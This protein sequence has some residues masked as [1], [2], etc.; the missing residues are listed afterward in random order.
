MKRSVSIL[1]VGV[2]LLCAGAVRADFI[3]WYVT[4]EADNGEDRGVVQFAIDPAQR[5]A[6]NLSFQL[7][8][9][10]SIMGTDNPSVALGTIQGLTV[11]LDGDPC[12]ALS[13]NVTSGA[14]A[15]TF[16]ISSATVSFS[17][18]HNPLAYASAAVTVTDNDSDGATLTGQLD[19]NNAYE[20]IY[21]TTQMWASLLEVPIV[22]GADDSVTGKGRQ[23]TV[24]PNR[25]T[26][27]ADVTSIQ[28]KFSF[29]LSANDQAS[30]TSRFDIIVPEPATLCLLALGGLAL[31]RR[32]RR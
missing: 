4:I 25:Q 6:G 10:V 28:S 2:V 30:G 12:V 31:L 11:G 17:A 23:P 3:G 24:A 8:G 26:I 22:A 1:V 19:G 16:T 14:S 18:I 29:T 15:T 21:N 27:F 5:T 9:P 32:R 13:F 7:P 20:A